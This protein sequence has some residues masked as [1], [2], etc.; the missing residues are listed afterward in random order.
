[1]SSTNDSKETIALKGRYGSIEALVAYYKRVGGVTLL[2]GPSG[3]GKSYIG[4]LFKARPLDTIGYLNQGK[5]MA[6]TDKYKGDNLWEGTADNINSL[7]PLTD[8]VIFIVP[9]LED[10]RMM[11]RAKA[12][13]PKC[14]PGLRNEFDVRS[15]FDK[16]QFDKMIADS[17]KKFVDVDLTVVYLSKHLTRVP[18]KG[19]H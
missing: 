1:M 19:W 4:Q 3:S 15:R 10:F 17:L 6:D 14:P 13:D 18:E 7:L 16:D 5:W 12:L 2:T 8:Q 9:N 11:N